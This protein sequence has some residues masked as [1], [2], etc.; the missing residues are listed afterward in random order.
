MSDNSSNKMSYGP[1]GIIALQSCKDLGNRIDNS[2]KEMR[3]DKLCKSHSTFLISTEE[4]RF[5]NGEGKVRIEETVRGKDV[6]ILCDV[7]NYSCTYEMF[8]FTNH[9]GPDEHFQDIKRVVSAIGGKA[10]RVSVIMPL[11]YAG[12][13]HRRKGRESLDCAMALQELESLGVRDIF[14]FDVHDP[15]VQNAVPLMSFQNIYPT[16]EIV[17][18]IIKNEPDISIDKSK[19]ITI[20]PDTGAM[21]RA[22]YY[23]SVLGLDIGLFYKRRDYSE[24]VKGKNPIVQHE[25]MGRDIE[26]MDVLVVDDMIASGESIF[27]IVVELNKRKAG[28]VY[29]AATFAMFTEGIQKFEDF[30]RAGLISRVYSTNLTHIPPQVREAEWFRE[31][32]MAGFIANVINYV[33]CDKSLA[34][35]TQTTKNIKQLMNEMGKGI[36]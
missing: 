16:Y 36:V 8:G 29:V 12:R 28:R 19:M 30:Y 26:G 2:L 17:K 18:S 31:V 4:V 7:G 15:N 5:S 34:P 21:D 22:I 10:R 20:S 25:Y 27:D 13:Q 24:I 1:L 9:M 33:N 11:M 6:Y 32:D 23:S 14:T 3:E 35:I